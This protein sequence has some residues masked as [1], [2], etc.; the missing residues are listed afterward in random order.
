[1]FLVFAVY[2]STPNPS[3]TF[4]I[5]GS[6][7]CSQFVQFL[8]TITCIMMI[9]CDA[10]TVQSRLLMR[11]GIAP[12]PRVPARANWSDAIGLLV[13]GIIKGLRREIPQ[14]TSLERIEQADELA[15]RLT[16]VCKKQGYDRTF[17]ILNWSQFGTS[18]ELDGNGM[19]A[20]ERGDL[21][22]ALTMGHRVVV[23]V[24]HWCDNFAKIRPFS[25]SDPNFSENISTTRACMHG[26]GGCVTVEDSVCSATS[27]PPNFVGVGDR[28]SCCNSTSNTYMRPSSLRL[29]SNSAHFSYKATCEFSCA[30][31][32]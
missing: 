6:P 4:Q 21:G 2:P 23:A 16:Q 14:W 27:R 20:M 28:G 9:T 1:M 13:E 30:P 12:A 32:L 5:V 8:S 31:L 22:V 15:N 10:E 11:S 25:L 19:S 3:Y 26:G 18:N 7:H 24:Q 17:F 29:M